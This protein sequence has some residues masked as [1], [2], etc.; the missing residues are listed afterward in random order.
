MRLFQRIFKTRI[1]PAQHTHVLQQQQQGLPKWLSG[2][3]TDPTT[4]F[5]FIFYIIHNLNQ[6]SE[7]TFYKLML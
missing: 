6:Q 2:T 7:F 5:I 1:L 3:P 4:V